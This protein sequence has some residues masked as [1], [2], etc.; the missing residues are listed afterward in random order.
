M[1]LTITR[2][3]SVLEFRNENAEA[4]DGAVGTL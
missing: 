1:T 4:G 2:I 3:A